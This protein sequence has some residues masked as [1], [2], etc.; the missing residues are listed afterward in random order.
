L[1]AALLPVAASTVWKPLHDD[2]PGGESIVAF[3]FAGSVD[4]AEEILDTWRAEGVIDEAKTIQVLDLIYPLV[5]ALAFAGACIAASGA[6]ERAG[7]PRI[8]RTGVAMAW[9]AFAA[10]GFD[11]LENLGL[12]VSLWDEPASPWPQLAFGA[13][14]VKFAS[15]GLSLLYGASGPFAGIAGRRR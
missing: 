4:R 9:V 15:I 7:R 10:A 6:W 2:E 5:Y 1:V 3:E 8:A 12:G 14:V 13:A 11:Y